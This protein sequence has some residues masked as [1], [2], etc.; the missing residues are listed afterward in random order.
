MK[1][2]AKSWAAVLA[3]IALSAACSDVTFEGGGPVSISLTA[4]RA[5]AVVGQ[6]VTFT[7]DVTGELLDRV[8]I[9]Y[10]DGVADTIVT[11]G[12]QSAHGRAVHA[13]DTAGSF[14]VLGVAYDGVQGP[15]SATVAIQVTGG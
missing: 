8:T 4:D 12:A 10:G 13:Y 1:R 15:D 9:E 6:D 2:R 14:T 7:Y 11:N 3:V 5:S